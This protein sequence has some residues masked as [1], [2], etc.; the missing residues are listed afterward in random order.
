MIKL[1][2]LTLLIGFAF[3]VH[4]GSQAIRSDIRAE[5]SCLE[6]AKGRAET[7]KC[8]AMIKMN[9]AKR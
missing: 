2:G 7:D 3:Y 4:E 5:Q 8:I 9:I 6:S 1:L